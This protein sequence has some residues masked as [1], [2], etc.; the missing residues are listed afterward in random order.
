MSA[1]DR[2][3]YIRTNDAMLDALDKETEHRR[4]EATLAEND[5]TRTDVA[6]KLIVEALA[7]A[8]ARRAKA[9]KSR[10]AAR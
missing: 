10:K 6:R 3:L 9:R 7:A 5:I 2:V 1:L 4:R 8:N